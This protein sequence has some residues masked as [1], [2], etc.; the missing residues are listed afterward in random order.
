MLGDKPAIATVAVKNIDVAKKFYEETLEL[1][2]SKDQ[3][4][5]TLSYDTPGSTI[6]VYPSQYAG[7][8]EATAL[9]WMVND[10]EKTVGD[11]KS[12]GVKFEH[13][14]NLPETKRQGDIHTGGDKKLAWFKDP[15]GNI[16]A[17]IGE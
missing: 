1:Q 2:P 17:L 13:Y 9:T 7:T 10:V 8:N 6:F 4:P 15:D 12:K 14:D 5:G 16:H 11:L 3:E